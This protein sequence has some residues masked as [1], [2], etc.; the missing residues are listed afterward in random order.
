VSSVR[1]IGN[2]AEKFSAS[3]V[4]LVEEASLDAAGSEM[5]RQRGQQVGAENLQLLP[6]ARS[7]SA[8]KVSLPGRE[9]AGRNVKRVPIGT[10]R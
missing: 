10:P 2:V 7:E 5:V 4:D 6:G 3:R 8:T 9:E 1:Y